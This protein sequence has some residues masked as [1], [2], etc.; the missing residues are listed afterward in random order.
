[1][2]QGRL[3]GGTTR[4]QYLELG[5]LLAHQVSLCE[6][7]KGAVLTTGSFVQGTQLGSPSVSWIQSLL[8]LLAWCLCDISNLPAFHENLGTILVY[9]FTGAAVKLYHKLQ[10]IEMYTLS[11]LEARNPK[12]RC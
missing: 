8:T 6:E 11:I 9:Y 5:L 12:Y 2:G 10:T 4:E 1:M 3:P 7:E